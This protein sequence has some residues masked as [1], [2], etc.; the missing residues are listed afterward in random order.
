M[1]VA[2]LYLI[3]ALLII[4][5]LFVMVRTIVFQRRQGAVKAIEGDPGR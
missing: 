3:L 4:T 2:L 5:T 1:L